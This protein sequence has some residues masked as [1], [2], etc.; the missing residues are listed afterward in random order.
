MDQ[1]TEL[2]TIFS[3]LIAEAIGLPADS[4]EKYFDSSEE[5][6]SGTKRQDRLK[7]IKYP[8]LGELGEKATEQGG[9]RIA[10]SIFTFII[11]VRLLGL[12]LCL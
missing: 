10:P 4:F 8:D 9:E 6:A 1:M 5:S 3:S 12:M 7:V 2:S 11:P